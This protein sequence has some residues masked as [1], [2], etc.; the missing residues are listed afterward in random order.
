MLELGLLIRKG[1]EDIDEGLFWVNGL[2]T[3]A[4]VAVEDVEEGRFNL[5]GAIEPDV[6]FVG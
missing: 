4:V 6:E 3:G 1:F 5:K 2:V